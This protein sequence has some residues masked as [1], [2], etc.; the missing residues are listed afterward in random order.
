MRRHIL[1]CYNMLFGKLYNHPDFIKIK[2][3]NPKIM[4]IGIL[5]LTYK[6]S[7]PLP[8][9]LLNCHSPCFILVANDIPVIS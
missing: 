2:L 1:K 7:L 3:V 8:S 5:G 6:R 4:D 9:V